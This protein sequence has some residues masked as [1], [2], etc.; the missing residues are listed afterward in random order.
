MLWCWLL[1][2][3]TSQL[4]L[5]LAAGLPRPTVCQ[6]EHVTYLRCHFC[7]YTACC[8]HVILKAMVQVL[9]GRQ[10]AIAWLVRAPDMIRACT[11]ALRTARDV[12][13]VS[14]HA[15]S[16]LKYLDGM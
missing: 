10:D 2:T 9:E 7:L 12:T 3:G 16:C 5:Q 11:G 6:G 8:Q 15:C 13:M 1:A 4:T 14:T